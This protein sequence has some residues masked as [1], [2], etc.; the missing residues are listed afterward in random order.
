MIG[1]TLKKKIG[2][3]LE[4]FCKEKVL[5]QVTVLHVDGDKSEHITHIKG[6]QY[7]ANYELQNGQT[8]WH[9]VKSGNE[10]RLMQTVYKELG[11]VERITKALRG[12]R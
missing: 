8:I 6:F 7:A 5:K 1:I 4:E 9:Q 11:T 2:K 12:E 10:M 3:T